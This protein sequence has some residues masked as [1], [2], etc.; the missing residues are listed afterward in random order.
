M[1]RIWQWAWD[2]YGRWY[3]WAVL[4]VMFPLVL[5]IYLMLSFAVVAYEGSRHYVEA[6]AVAGFGLLA[7]AMSLAV[8]LLIWA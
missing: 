1:D 3:S 2:R 6:A 8:G 7:S 5:Q 4:A